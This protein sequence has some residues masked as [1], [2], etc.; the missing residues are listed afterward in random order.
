MGNFDYEQVKNPLFFKENVLPAHSAHVVYRNEEEFMTRQTSLRKSLDGIWKFS[1]AVNFDSSIKGFEKEEYDCKCWADIRV[2][3]HIQ[4]EGYDKPQYVNL[5]YP[6]DGREDINPGDIPERFNPVASYVKYFEVPDDM[7]G[8]EIR[9]S[10]QGVE[11]AMAL[12]INGSY[13]GYS[14]DSFTP[15][16]FNITPFLKEGE[17][18]LAVQVYK[19]SSSSWCEDQDFFRFSGIY[20]SVYL[21]AV[22][23]VY[24]EDIRIKTLFEGDDFSKAVL[25]VWTKVSL[26]DRNVG[27][28]NGNDVAPNGNGDISGTIRFTLKDEKTVLFERDIDINK[29]SIQ[30]IKLSE[31]VVSPRLWSAETPELY[32]LEIRVIDSEG[33]IKGYTEQPVGFRKFEMKNNRMLLNGKR[34]VFKGVNRHEFSSVSGR[35]VSYEELEKDIVTMKQNNINAI[36]TCHYPDDVAIYDLCDKYGLY[37]IAE[38]NMETHGTWDVYIRGLAGIDYVLPDEKENWKDM[39]FDRVNSCYQRDKNHPSIL[40]WSCG[41]ESYGGKTIL[42]MSELFRKLDD[43]RLVHYEGV[44]NDRRYNDSSD[45]ESR[46]YP[47]VWEIEEYLETPDVKPFVCCEYSHAM[48][49]SCGALYKYTDLADKENSGYQGGF[50]WD[51]IDQSIYKKD[52]YGKEFQAYGGDFGDRPS[53]YNFSGNGIV[54]GGDRSPSPKM[55]EVKYTY[56]NIAVEVSGKDFEVW[57]KNLFVNT[58]TFDAKAILLRNGVAI[59]EKSLDICVE[60]E[61]KRKFPI[62]FEIPSIKGEY[63]VTISFHLKTDTLWAKAGHEVA[64]GQAVVALVKDTHTVHTDRKKS[65]TLIRGKYNFGVRGEEFEALFSIEGG[66]V[67]Y[68]YAGKELLSTTVKPNFWRAPIDNDEGNNMPAR[69]AQWKVA[70]LYLTAKGVGKERKT[71]RGI[72]YDNPIVA[73]KEDCVEI[74]YTYNLQ[75]TPAA[76]CQVIYRVY[77]DGRIQTTL[78]YD[79]VQELKDMPEFGMMFKCDADYENLEWYGNGPQESY[80]DRK[81]GAKLGVYK[82]LVSDNMAQYLNP[83][84]CGNKT[85]VRYAKV[86][87]RK[88]RGLIFTGENMNFS[89]LPYT[90]HELENA[91]HPYELPQVH[92]TVVRVSMQ[93][94]GV[95]GD[96]SWGALV[97]PEFLIDA[98]KKLSFTFTFC[99]I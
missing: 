58:D 96:D 26:G 68:R 41:N 30:E 10:F 82:N 74:T 9:I 36:R 38:C 19:W 53:D 25:D 99:G 12:W 22:P 50:I 87:D 79:P 67:S 17:N 27:S 54:Y 76:E 45:M 77:G 37:M 43:T 21:Y 91:R 24:V 40:M 63:A 42:E 56:Q 70:S 47:K 14:E 20:R 66:L 83:Q 78:N 69:Y 1:Y 28:A 94:M 8:N 51:Y 33:K 86:M 59:E 65:Y 89:A 29:S 73:E 72:W 3:A 4:M 55:Q 88:G 61:S 18:K 90:P 93:Q 16:D 49:N 71:E 35:H 31:V 39:M 7:K 23:N 48:G 13:V 64:F 84:E 97:H 34:V 80:E 62:P 57:N 81:K 44:F 11:S 92:Y 2:P 52:R 46:M 85:G 5:Q 6:W 95:G 98:T 75:T 60:P 15:S 32:T